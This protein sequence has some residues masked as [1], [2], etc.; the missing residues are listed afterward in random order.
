[1]VRL[2]REIE[3]VRADRAVPPP[4]YSLDLIGRDAVLPAFAERVRA[5]EPGRTLLA[6]TQWPELAAELARAGH[7]VT[8]ADVAEFEVATL[9]ARLTPDV[10]ARL[11]IQAKPYGDAAFSPSSFD[12]VVL[13]DALH[14][15]Q[16]PVWLLKKAAR[17]LKPDG[18]LVLRALVHGAVPDGPAGVG[19][20]RGRI[21]ANVL[22]AVERGARSAA[23]PWLVD[24]AAREALDRG[25]HLQS[26]RFAQP[27]A[28]V[29]AAVAGAQL[30]Q[31]SLL[32]GHT[33]RLRV[34]DLLYG[35]R[36]LARHL[37]RALAARLPTEA[38]T[39]DRAAETSRAVLVVARR[40]LRAPVVH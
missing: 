10:A 9:H 3:G 11:T 18:V 25:A 37:L 6:G 39:V 5:L 16:E 31:D 36:G 27:L 34:A 32:A 30:A 35:S 26:D 29:L 15:Y 2:R 23:A 13:A 20:S 38:D 17:E 8:L 28:E 22:A 33:Q 1:M 7:W 40:A 12:Y 19:K 4:G 14:R 24:A 21:A